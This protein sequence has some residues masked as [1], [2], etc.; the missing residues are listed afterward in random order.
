MSDVDTGTDPG[1]TTAQLANGVILVKSTTLDSTARAWCIVASEK[2]A[3]F[4]VNAPATT[5]SG[6]TGVPYFPA[7]FG[8]FVSLKPGDA[9]NFA[10]ISNQL[11]SFTGSNTT[12]NSLFYGGNA[13][14]GSSVGQGGWT[15][16]S[17]SAASG[18]APISGILSVTGAAW[19]GGNVEAS[20]PHPVTGGLLI[21]RI[22]LKEAGA[23][24]LRGYLPNVYSPLH[25]RPF[26]N[27]DVKTDVQDLPVGTEL[28]VKDYSGSNVNPST[29]DIGQ[30]FFDVINAW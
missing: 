1:P 2:F 9:Y 11:T 10:V 29:S 6:L 4:F 27:G 28:Y 17:H 19:R 13:L 22:L 16:R 5:I 21:E 3:Y 14:S 18:A 7:F 8:D 26:A 25:H 24:V 12:V 15:L 20:Y 30:V 23:H